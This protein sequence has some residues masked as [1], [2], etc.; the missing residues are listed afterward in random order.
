M[1]QSENGS[2]E[3]N[4]GEKPLIL[5]GK[6]SSVLLYEVTEHE[7]DTLE[8]GT[9]TSLF[10]NFGIALLSISCSFLIALLT[11]NIESD[12]LFMVLTF[13]VI[14]GFISGIILMCLWWRDRQSSSELIKKIKSR[15]PDKESESSEQD[16][17]EE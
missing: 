17:D 11:T 5:R 2:Q 10:L 13:I 16:E 7:L 1:S 12:R 3:K 15:I 4:S 9:P 14:V 6:V 8:K